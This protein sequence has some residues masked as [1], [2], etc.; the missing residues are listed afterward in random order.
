MTSAPEEFPYLLVGLQPRSSQK[1]RI[2]V[3]QGA[4]AARVGYKS[5]FIRHPQ[6]REPSGC[7]TAASRTLLVAAVKEAVRRVDLPICIVL[8]SA[9]STI[10]R[11]G[12][13]TP[14]HSL[15]VPAGGTSL[16][17]PVI[18][19]FRDT[20]P[21]SPLLPFDVADLPGDRASRGGLQSL[22]PFLRA[23]A[24]ELRLRR[25][26]PRQDKRHLGVVIDWGHSEVG[27]CSEAPLSVRVSTAEEGATL[28][29]KRE[30]AILE[31]FIS[32][33]L[34]IREGINDGS[35]IDDGSFQYVIAQLVTRGEVEASFPLLASPSAAIRPIL[36]VPS[37]TSGQRTGTSCSALESS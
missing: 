17:A 13:G 26:R 11:R 4:P 28:L 31:E 1:E 12:E 37:R 5:T 7:L 6:P 29:A 20:H 27:S 22:S 23:K 9:L 24:E 15:Q 34:Q 35:L 32:G 36:N 3:L 14:Q 8:G 16:P 21:E 2:Q 25:T 19:D 18:F 10:V 30:G 33:V